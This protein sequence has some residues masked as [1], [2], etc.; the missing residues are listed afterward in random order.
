M[1]ALE[2]LEDSFIFFQ[3]GIQHMFIKNTYNILVW[4]NRVSKKIY[5]L[6]FLFKI[7]FLPQAE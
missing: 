6:T 3:Y 2:A 7:L 1:Y 4:V 5:N